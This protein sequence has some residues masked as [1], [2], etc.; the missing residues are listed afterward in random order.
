MS[1]VPERRIIKHGFALWTNSSSTV[2]W[3][4][5]GKDWAE[6][7]IEGTWWERM[8]RET[9]LN[10]VAP[11]F[12][13][14]MGFVLEFYRNKLRKHVGPNGIWVAVKVIN[15]EALASPP[16]VYAKKRTAA[17]KMKTPDPWEPTQWN[18]L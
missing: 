12:G 8:A 6:G 2:V 14:A 9:V 1:N 7:L 11:F 17:N 18:I 16:L 4:E 15:P 5:A 13:T 10:M 3:F